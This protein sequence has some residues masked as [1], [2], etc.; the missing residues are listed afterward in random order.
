MTD[1]DGNLL[2]PGVELDAY[3]NGAVC[4]QWIADNY[5]AEGF[6]VGDM[7][8]LGYIVAT[9]SNVVSFNERAAG[10][11]ETFQ[12]AFPD[13]ENIYTADTLAQS[14]LT[15]DAAYTEVAAILSAHP[16][17]TTWFVVGILDDLAQGAVR[18]LEA[19]GLDDQALVA[20]VGGEVLV[21]EWDTGYEGCWKACGY[22]EAMDF[23]KQDVPALMSVIRGEATL[24]DLFPEYKEPGQEYGAYQ[25][26][27]DICT[28][29]TYQEVR[30][31][32][33]A[34]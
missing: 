16:E 28:K 2:R 15:A 1:E 14:A 22:F 29:D 34:S 30:A 17:I 7:S 26:V 31:A 9:Y 23:V 8:T 11:T 3:Q 32:H 27:G 12:A 18:A 10:A 4:S 6:D 20:S 24:E 21:Q 13:C 33:Q 5:E 25:I 19:A